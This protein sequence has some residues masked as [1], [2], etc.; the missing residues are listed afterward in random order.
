MNS[1]Q[2]P[3]DRSRSIRALVK[4]IAVIIITLS[5]LSAAAYFGVNWFLGNQMTVLRESFSEQEI[6]HMSDTYH[7]STEGLLTPLYTFEQGTAESRS[8]YSGIVM[9]V[10]GDIADV[11]TRC[12]GQ[13]ADGEQYLTNYH[14]FQDYFVDDCFEGD[15]TRLKTRDGSVK[16]IRCRTDFPDYTYYFYAAENVYY[17]MAR[18]LV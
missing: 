10:D 15:T 3:Y 14:D 1:Y 13:P 11:L 18:R 2:T 12:F 17:L 9:R 6:K 7:I 5:I 8:Q 16:A 4:P